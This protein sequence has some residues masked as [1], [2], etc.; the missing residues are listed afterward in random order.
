MSDKQLPTADPEKPTVYEIRLDGHLGG[1]WLAWF[2]DATIVLERNGE[3]RLTCAVVDQA[4]LHAL[5]RKV[6]DLG[7]PL[8]AVTRVQGPSGV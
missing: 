2:E 6:R 1:H 8:L 3:T 5:L 4:A 7:I